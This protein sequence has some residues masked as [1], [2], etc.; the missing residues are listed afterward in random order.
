[1]A[2][3]SDFSESDADSG[4][5]SSAAEDLDGLK[6]LKE[7]AVVQQA[8]ELPSAQ[9]LKAIFEASDLFKSN[10]FKLQVSIHQFIFTNE[11][12]SCYR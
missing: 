7:K 11:T 2:N 4:S 5:E 6:T 1:M 9:E 10:A 8:R 3:D 12:N